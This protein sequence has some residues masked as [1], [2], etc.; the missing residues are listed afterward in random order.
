[1]W[2]CVERLQLIYGEAYAVSIAIYHLDTDN[3]FQFFCHLI[4]LLFI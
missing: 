2:A 1:M 3:E 4:R